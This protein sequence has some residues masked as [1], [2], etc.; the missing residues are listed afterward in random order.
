MWEL[1]ISRSTY[2]G[3]G[4]NCRHLHDS[5]HLMT[6]RSIFVW[7]KSSSFAALD[8]I[9]DSNLRKWFVWVLHLDLLKIHTFGSLCLWIQWK[10]CSHCSEVSRFWILYLGQITENREPI[11]LKMLANPCGF[12]WNPAKF[13]IPLL[14]IHVSPN[15]TAFLC[16]N[17]WTL[18]S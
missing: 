3:N 12:D 2:V 8:A 6:F 18:N 14:F 4:R 13:K 10:K 16:F 9:C 5:W 7:V 15:Q 11:I 1:R 17:F